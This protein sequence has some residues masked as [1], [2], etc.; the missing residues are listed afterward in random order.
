M[1]PLSQTMEELREKFSDMTEE[2]NTVCGYD[3][4]TR[5]NVRFVGDCKCV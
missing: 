3:S 2:E 4:R 5:G 1:K